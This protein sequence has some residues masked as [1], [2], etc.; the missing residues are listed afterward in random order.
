MLVDIVGHDVHASIPFYVGLSMKLF[1]IGVRSLG[2][3]NGIIGSGLFHAR[4]QRTR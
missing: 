1:V 4:K 2:K 3:K